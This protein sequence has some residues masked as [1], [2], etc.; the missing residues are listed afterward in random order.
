MLAVPAS[1]STI[2]AARTPR[3]MA[4]TRKNVAGARYTQWGQVED[5][6]LAVVEMLLGE[7]TAAA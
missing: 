3:T 6:L 4:T 1:P 2:T 7:G 5:D